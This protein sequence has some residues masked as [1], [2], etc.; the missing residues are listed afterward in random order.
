MYVYIYI[1]IY[2]TQKGDDY[3]LSRLRRGLAPL[4]SPAGAA[5]LGMVLE[6]V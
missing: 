2:N 4:P 1:Y 5:P 3:T 6:I